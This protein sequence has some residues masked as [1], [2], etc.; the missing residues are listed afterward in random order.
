ML[1]KQRRMH[2]EISSFTSEFI[3]NSKVKDH[4]DAQKRKLIAAR[5]PF[6]DKATMLIDLAK[7]GALALTDSSSHSRFNI[8]SGLMSIHLAL[9]SKKNNLDSIGIITPYKAQARFITSCL[10]ELQGKNY[11][12]D[13]QPIVASTVHRFQGSERDLIIFDVVDSFP[14]KKPSVLLTDKNSTRLVNVAVTRARGKFIQIRDCHYGKSRYS[15]QLAITNLT[16]HIYDQFNISTRYEH[17]EFLSEEVSKRLKWFSS[18]Q[19]TE[20]NDFL[21]ELYAAKK[22]IILSISDISRLNPKIWKLIHEKSKKVKVVIYTLDELEKAGSIHVIP[23]NLVG[24]FAIIDDAVLWVGVPVVV[25]T[26]YESEPKPPYFSLRLHA[27]ETIAILKGNTGI[28]EKIKFKKGKV[29]N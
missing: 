27:P 3:Y 9:L 8:M 13:A 21:K 4:K 6:P 2:P 16:N 19:P 14:Q 28:D 25:G 10:K 12:E 18:R 17:Q 29:G 11:I 23:K 24:S 15:K 1:D 26:K 20:P 22:S 5:P 7:M